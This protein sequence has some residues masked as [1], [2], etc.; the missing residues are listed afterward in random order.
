MDKKINDN[1][2]LV[3]ALKI[4]LFSKKMQRLLNFWTY[5]AVIGVEDFLKKDVVR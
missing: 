4:N 2:S 3:F 1:Q 5:S